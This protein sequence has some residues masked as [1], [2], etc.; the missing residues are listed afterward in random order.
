MLWQN[1]DCRGYAKRLHG[2]LGTKEAVEIVPYVK[3]VIESFDGKVFLLI[4]TKE[5]LKP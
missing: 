2:A 5:R 1:S 3:D 4:A